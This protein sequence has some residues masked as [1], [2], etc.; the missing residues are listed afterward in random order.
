MSREAPVMQCQ[1]NVR[2]F[3]RKHQVLHLCDKMDSVNGRK[4]EVRHFH[5]VDGSKQDETVKKD[6]GAENTSYCY[7]SRKATKP[8]KANGPWIGSVMGGQFA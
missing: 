6:D 1:L 8:I 2:H 7:W 4:I 3:C 5:A